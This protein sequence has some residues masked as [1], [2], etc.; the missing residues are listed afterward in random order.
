MTSAEQE[1]HDVIVIGGGAA[2]LNGALMLGRSRRSVL[3]VDA[4]DPRNAPAAGVH[5]F[6]TRDGTPPAELMALGRAEVARYG[7]EVTEGRAVSARRTDSGFSVTL[8]DGRTVEGRRLLVTT[9]LHDELPDIAG[10]R[11]R[12]G[13]EVVHCPYCHGWEVRDEPIGVLVTGPRATHVAQLFRQMTPEV[14]MFLHDGPRPTDDEIEGLQARGVELVEGHVDSLV[15]EDDRLTG[16]R[17]D[18][19]RVVACRAVAVTPTFAAR[20]GVLASLGLEPTD[21]PSGMGTHIA[22]DATGATAMTGVWV[23]GNVTDPMAQVGASAA[24]GALAGAAI[25]AD[26][27]AEDVQ[28]AVHGAAQLPS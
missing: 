2:G 20:A 11:E 5:G 9:G 14:T 13:R 28:L 27:V 24:A 21:H 12:W 17:L 22:C 8:E 19:G 26:L 10:L 16:V 3:V 4:G 18:D 23:A 1:L 15:V 6:L 7:V 25:N